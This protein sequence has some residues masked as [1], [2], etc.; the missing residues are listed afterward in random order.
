MFKST[1][2]PG[3]YQQK[4]LF[5]DVVLKE[6]DGIEIERPPFGIQSKR[7]DSSKHL[8]PGPGSY[9]DQRTALNSLN[10]IHGLKKT[11]FSQSSVRFEFNNVF[12]SKSA[13]GPGQY[14]LNGFAEENLRKAI[15]DSN[16]KPAFGQSAERKFS[17]AK[18]DDYALPGPAQY[19]LTEKP[20][21]SKKENFSSNFA[22]TTKQREILFE[23]NNF[24]R[25]NNFLSKVYL[26]FLQD[27]P[28]PTA[29]DSA[30]SY[31]FLIN[32]RRKPPRN[33]NATRRQQ[34]FNVVSRRDFNL[35]NSNEIPGPG[36]YDISENSK[37]KTCIAPLSEKRWKDLNENLPGP[38]HY[39]LSTMYQDT[40]L[41]G[42]LISE[43][44]LT[45][46]IY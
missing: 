10:K 34:S 27:T 26:S 4:R 28:G 8:A 21:K 1:P 6:T 2:G 14:R 46:S 3:K 35:V 42:Y 39:E 17:L 9:N 29:Y 43:I 16:R 23:V 33:K 11:P 37:T 7:F 41:K 18:K 24:N 19:K 13:P 31:E 38:A 36:S 12:K 30:K 22:S 5:D 20:Y 40:I 15:I 32:S 25:I 45:Y 44:N